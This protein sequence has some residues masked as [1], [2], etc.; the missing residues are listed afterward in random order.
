MIDLIFFNNYP[1]VVFARGYIFISFV[2]TY[3]SDITKLFSV[4]VMI[5][6]CSI[7]KSVRC[8]GIL[9]FRC[10]VLYM[11]CMALHDMYLCYL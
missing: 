9:L 7:L 5:F 6:A 8:F 3:Y 10:K 4:F 1:R 11:I 2:I